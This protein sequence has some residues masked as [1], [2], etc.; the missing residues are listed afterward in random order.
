MHYCIITKVFVINHW[1]FWQFTKITKVNKKS[2]NK[3][4]NLSQCP[5]NT[6]WLTTELNCVQEYGLSSTQLCPRVWS[7][8]YSTMFK[9]K[10]CSVLMVCSQCSV[11]N[12]VQKYGLLSPQPCPRIWSAYWADHAQICPRMWSAQYSTLSGIMTKKKL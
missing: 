2:V 12:H 1:N 4:C 11:L 9:N 5:Y 3:F 7:A 10:V 6:Q 8:Q